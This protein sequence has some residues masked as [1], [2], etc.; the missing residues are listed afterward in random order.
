M[1]RVTFQST[2]GILR[3][4]GCGILY[5]QRG[6]NK[7]RFEDVP[8]DSWFLKERLTDKIAFCIPWSV[9]EP[10]EGNF[11]WRHSDWEGCIDSWI[12]AG[13]KVALEIRGMDTLGTFYNEG[14]PQ[15]VFDA[16]AKFV[17]EPI[18]NYRG[19]F[20]LNN[21]PDDSELPVRYPVYW[22][23][24]YLEKVEH[25]VSAMGER[26]NGRQEV[27]YVG[28]GHM[29][30]W[31]EMHIADHGP[32]KPWFDAGLSLEAYIKAHKRIIDI[33]RK[34]FPDT[35]LSQEICVP[36][37]G[38]AGQPDLF[39]MESAEPIFSY[40]AG[41]GIHI[42]QN[43]LGKAWRC[44]DSK[45]LDGPVKDLMMRYR[46][47]T[48]VCFENLVLPKALQEGL[49]CGI[50][51]WHRGGESQGLGIMRVEENIPVHNK[52]IYSFYRFFSEEYDELD[53]EAQKN[54]WRMMARKCGYRLELKEAMIPEKLE[55]GKVFACELKWNNSGSAKCHEKLET[56]LALFDRK[57]SLVVWSQAQGGGSK[58]WMLPARMPRGEFALLAGLRLPKRHGQMMQLPLKDE[59]APG[60]YLLADVSVDL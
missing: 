56:V 48:K 7:V 19:T 47:K 23:P 35:E 46:D 12:K 57:D 30:R 40:L 26:Y 45:Y 53:I 4:P 39:S 5:L 41:N 32:L 17:D 14:V 29:G 16:G 2:D 22:D 11:L 6:M 51:Y 58:E 34:A 18:K 9:I 8:K 49:D 3:N 42:K 38:E 20:L 10:E 44:C 54:I 52:G 24:V 36:V 55:L 28:I 33:Y 27:E 31:G 37:F 1:K 43:G 59:L 13:F 60:L 15:W 21:I 25:L 50:S